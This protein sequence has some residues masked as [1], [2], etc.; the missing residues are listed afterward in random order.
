MINA[1]YRDFPH[2]DFV[3]YRALSP[4]GDAPLVRV[5]ERVLLDLEAHRVDSIPEFR[6]LGATL[7]RGDGCLPFPAGAAII[8]TIATTG[9]HIMTVDDALRILAGRDCSGPEG[10]FLTN[11]NGWTSNVQDMADRLKIV[12]SLFPICERIVATRVAAMVI[13]LPCLPSPFRLWRRSLKKVMP[14]LPPRA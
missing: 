12:S 3:K 5:N 4:A 7:V 2:F 10:G 14:P 11:G 13:Y 6:K 1:A 8:A 9:W